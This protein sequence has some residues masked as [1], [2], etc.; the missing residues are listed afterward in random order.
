MMET[1]NQLA[2]RILGMK[3][4]IQSG[5]DIGVVQNL[6]I[7]L[8]TD[9]IAYVILCYA[10]FIGPMNR[11]YSISNNNG[12]LKLG[13]KGNVFLEIEKKTLLNAS[14]LKFDEYALK[15][16]SQNIDSVYELKHL[17]N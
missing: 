2:T 8:P 12:H 16:F 15:P 6:M 11:H 3:V 9:T 14:T 13:N 4:K 7:D 10:D 17:R 1:Y 5:N